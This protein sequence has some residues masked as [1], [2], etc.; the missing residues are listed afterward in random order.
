M[1]DDDN[2]NVQDGGAG[3]EASD[4][5]DS[6]KDSFKIFTIKLGGFKQMFFWTFGLP[7]LLILL[8]IGKL[9][10]PGAAAGSAKT[11]QT[12]TISLPAILCAAAS[13]G[14]VFLAILTKH[15]WLK[16]FLRVLLFVGTIALI[17]FSNKVGF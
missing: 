7:G 3:E 6:V 1:S 5:I 13:C 11:S 14:L 12:K 2:N 17:F 16:W 9:T 8:L 10:S 4:F 15:S